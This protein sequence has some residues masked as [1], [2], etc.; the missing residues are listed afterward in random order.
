MFH[1]IR[2]YYKHGD[3]NIFKCDTEEQLRLYLKQQYVKNQE[4]LK[5]FFELDPIENN[6]FEEENL[7]AL[8]DCVYEMGRKMIEDQLGYGV[9]Y[10]IR[11][12]ILASRLTTVS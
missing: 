3:S 7:D 2:V 10:V 9:K 6:Y 12:G 4:Y 11:G 5:D 1:V 8:I